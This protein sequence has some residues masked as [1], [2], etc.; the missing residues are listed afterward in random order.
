M[1]IALTSLC[2][3]PWLD[4]SGFAGPF[5]VSTD[6][7]LAVRLKHGVGHKWDKRKGCT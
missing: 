1:I 4:G 5:L 2:L 3:A 7:V 6:D